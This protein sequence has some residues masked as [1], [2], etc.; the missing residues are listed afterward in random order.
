MG[1]D[2]SNNDMELRARILILLWTCG[3]IIAQRSVLRAHMLIAI[4]V[5]YAVT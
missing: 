1:V 4:S 3:R 2:V 5:F